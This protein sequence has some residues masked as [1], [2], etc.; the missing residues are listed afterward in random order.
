MPY[1]KD[2]TGQL[3]LL[4]FIILL[5][6]FRPI[7]GF[8]KDFFHSAAVKSHNFRSYALY[9]GNSNSVRAPLLIVEKYN[10]IH[11]GQ[12]FYELYRDTALV[13]KIAL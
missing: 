1:P 6:T 2:R 13:E 5:F 10:F 9:K 7:N 11:A 12:F 4:L 8:A 3:I